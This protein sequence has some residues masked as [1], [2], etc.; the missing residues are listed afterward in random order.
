[1]PVSSIVKIYDVIID[2]LNFSA[3][4]CWDRNEIKDNYTN[5]LGRVTKTAA[6]ALLAKVYS[7]IASAKRSAI[8]GVVGNNL[9]LEFPESYSNYYQYA[10]KECYSAINVIGFKLSENL[11][12]WKTIFK[13]DN[14]NNPEMIFDVQGSSLTGQ[15][16]VY[17]IYFVQEAGLSGSGFRGINKLK[18]KFI[19]KRINKNDNRFKHSIITQYET[20][21]D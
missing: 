6:H 1:M 20:R 16:T 10:K 15:G 14:G 7:R 19:N 12:E 3:T 4:F 9:Y 2:D 5:N 18:G 11:E 8:D 21:K 17:Q 13:A